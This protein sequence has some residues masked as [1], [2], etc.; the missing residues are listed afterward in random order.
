M[1]KIFNFVCRAEAEIDLALLKRALKSV[2]PSAETRVSWVAVPGN[3][4]K[5]GNDYIGYGEVF[6]TPAD[7]VRAVS[8]VPDGH[9]IRETIRRNEPGID[10]SRLGRTQDHWVKRIGAC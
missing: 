4:S 6:C 3:P 1:K 5:P 2:D 7:F 9:V 10:L 8:A